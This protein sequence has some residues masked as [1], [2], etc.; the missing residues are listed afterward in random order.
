L[1]LNRQAA[2]AGVISLC[3]TQMESPLGPITMEIESEKPDALID[4]LTAH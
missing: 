2:F 1:L 3:T 4:W